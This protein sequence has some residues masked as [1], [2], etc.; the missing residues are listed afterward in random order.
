MSF[1]RRIVLERPDVQG[2]VRLDLRFAD[3]Q[4]VKADEQYLLDSIIDPDKQ[5]VQGYQPGVMSAVVKKGQ[6]SEA[7]AKLLVDFIEKSR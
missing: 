2:V 4:T 7:D 6:V 1:V 3:G 5:I